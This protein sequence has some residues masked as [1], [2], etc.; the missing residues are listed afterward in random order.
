M[1]IQPNFPSKHV[2]LSFRVLF[3]ASILG[4]ALPSALSQDGEEEDVFTLSP[5]SVQAEDDVGYRATSTLAGTRLKTEMKDLAN[6]ITVATREMMDDLNANDAAEVLQHLGNTESGGI[7]GNYSG[8]DSSA[9]F[10]D[11]VSPV[12][13]PQNANRIR[14]LA[15]ADN[16][17]NFF[18]T[19]INFD[20][21]S[22]DR[23]DVNRGANSTLFGLGSPGGIIN[24][25]TSAPIWRDTNRVGLNYGSFGSY[26]VTGNFN[27]VILEDKLAIRFAALYEEREW[28]QEPTYERDER[29]LFAITYKPVERG[30]LKFSYEQGVVDARRPRPNSPSDTLTRWWEP[31]SI[32]PNTGQRITWD[33]STQNFR[34]ID[35]DIYRAPGNWFFQTGVM[36]NGNADGSQADHAQLAWYNLP[37]G[38]QSYLVSIT[39]GQQYYPSATAA[40]QG[41]EFGS[42]WGHEEVQDR[43][44][45]DWVN[46]LLDGPNKQEWE[47]FNVFNA[48][49]DQNW[50]FGWGSAGIELSY[51]DENVNRGYFDLFPGSRG[52]TMQIDLN[53]HLQTGEVN[54]NFGRV[55]LAGRGQRRDNT[56]DRKT[57]RATAFFEYDFGR[58]DNKWIRWLGRQTTTVFGQDF[59]NDYLQL[60][61]ENRVSESYVAAI[62]GGTDLNSNIGQARTVVHVGPDLSQLNS[63]VGANIQPVNFELN[64]GPITG[65]GRINNEIVTGIPLE[66]YDVRDS[67]MSRNLVHAFTNNRS[68][69]SS[70]AMVHQSRMLDGGLVVTYGARNDRVRNYDRDDFSRNAIDMIDLSTIAIDT[71]TVTQNFEANTQSIGAVLHVDR[72]L[73]LPGETGLTLHWGEAENF[74]ISGPRRDMFGRPISPPGGET[75]DMGFSASFFNGKLVTRVNWYESA[76]TNV[77]FGIPGFL[78]ETDRRI[79]RYNSP[80]ALAAA[81]YQGPPDFYKE[82]TNWQIV[83]GASSDSGYNVT[84]SGAPSLSDTQSTASEG[85]EIDVSYNPNEKWR[86]VF[87]IAQQEAARSNLAPATQEYLTYRF[88]EWVNGAGKVLIADESNQTVDVRIFDTLLN[89]LNASLSREGQS[90]P[91]LAEWRW[92]LI[93]NHTFDQDSMLGGFNVG[94]SLNWTDDKAIGFPFMNVVQDSGDSIAI[95]DLSNPWTDDS[96]YRLNLFVGYNTKLGDKIDWR[97]QLNANN[98]LEDGQIVTVAVQPDGSSRSVV[99]REGIVFNLRSTFKF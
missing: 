41:I 5:F 70:L 4:L 43:S 8:V 59:V 74:Q 51:A 91:E 66:V 68:F 30:S 65:W 62:T 81:G 40:A 9:A 36:Y 23:V 73:K 61:S 58:S 32:D 38:F 95:P 69:T 83:D 42:F 11:H 46:N 71:E 57:Q 60:Q 84:Q 22:I 37:G 14:G 28:R 2:A 48:S 87:N 12:R 52:Y 55:F 6:S 39:T 92:N 82:L 85:L 7:D 1:S 80:E 27:R 35:R 64:T 88:D 67:G 20:G 94:G 21:Y 45:F 19:G 72:F 15:R 78:F 79:I 34:T 99:W 56:N 18:P 86:F 90:V 53:T 50:D 3:G 75:T 33:P 49:Y 63:P 97:L 44:I 98:V 26:R 77:N 76:S 13:N 31:Q 25:Q 24:H 29:S 10:V 89:G 93:A 47:S 17:R 54:S 96:R 16:T